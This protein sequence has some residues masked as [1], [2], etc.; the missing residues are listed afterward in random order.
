MADDTARERRRAYDREWTRKWR[1]E[2]P[3]KAREVSRLNSRRWRE[4]N[5]E[6]KA[7]EGK[8]YYEQHRDEV[9]RR[10]R[11]RRQQ[12]GPDRKKMQWTHGKNWQAASAVFW[13]AQEGC[14]Y[15]C[16]DPLKSDTPQ[17]VV[18]DHDHGCCP[19]RRSCD[20]CRRGLACGRCNKL[21]G[22]ANED[23]ARLRRIADALEAANALVQARLP[24]RP[25]QEAMF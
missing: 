18:I 9:L 5:P 7:E 14:C 22:L 4:K 12:R 17:A 8:L 20:I 19:Q 1:A 10:Q 15:L 21:L 3:E 11:E 2:N 6:A 16:G 25:V 13:E 24:R 23:P